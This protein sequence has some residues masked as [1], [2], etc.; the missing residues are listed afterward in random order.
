MDIL[1]TFQKTIARQVPNGQ[2]RKLLCMSKF[3][4]ALKLGPVV[5]Y[6]AMTQPPMG[7]IMADFIETGKDLHQ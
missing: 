3:H 4:R 6:S 1:E 5:N 2:C 7:A